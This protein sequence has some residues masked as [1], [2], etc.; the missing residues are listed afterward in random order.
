VNAWIRAAGHFDA[1][2]DFDKPSSAT[3]STPTISCP[4]TT[5]DHLHPSPAGYKAMGAIPLSLFA[6]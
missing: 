2:I 3:L 5:G 4:P 6:R 1:V